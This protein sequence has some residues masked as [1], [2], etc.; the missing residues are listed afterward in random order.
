MSKQSTRKRARRQKRLAQRVV[1]SRLIQ[2]NDDE[3]LDEE[4]DPVEVSDLIDR[5]EDFDRRITQRGWTFDAVNSTP[6][7][8]SWFFAPSGFEPDSDDVESVTRVWFTTPGDFPHSLQVILAGAG[9]DDQPQ[10]LSVDG[11]FEEL[12]GIEAHRAC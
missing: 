6:G 12:D 2:D 1:W 10:R 3:L 7:L 9:A 11:F 5:A 4:D 8:A